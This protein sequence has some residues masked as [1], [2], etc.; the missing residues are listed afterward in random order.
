MTLKI[1]HTESSTGWGG[2]EHRT[3]KELVALRERGHHLEVACR[4]GAQLGDRAAEAGFTVH[5]ISMRG[6]GDLIA[7]W[8][9]FKLLRRE[10]YDIVNTHSGHDSLLAGLA[11]R[12][13]RT[14]LI[15][16][17]RHLA[18]AISS[19]ATYKTLPHKVVAVSDWVRKYLISEGVPANDVTTIYTGIEPPALVSRS[20]LR[21]ELHLTAD[22]ILICTVA[23]LRYEKGHRDLIDAAAPLLAE[24]PKLHLVFAGDGP[25]FNE[26]SDYITEKGLAGRIHLLGLRRDIPNVL[27]GCDFFALATWQEALGTSFIEAMASGLAVIG[28]A[29]DGV[30][31]VITDGKNGILAPARNP[32]QLREALRQLIDQSELRSAMGAAGEEITRTRF[33]VATMAAEMESFYLK[34]LAE[35]SAG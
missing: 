9:I 19:L 10:R 21:D 12:L 15:V 23:I 3:F 18:L 29:V 11:G 26:L 27:A 6:G 22:D 2:Q 8:K 31:E 1:L 35:R 7:A 24:N 34:S 14:P 33:S 16:R 5:R 30:P 25:I 4:P 13:A 28:S 17:T 20:T 32:V